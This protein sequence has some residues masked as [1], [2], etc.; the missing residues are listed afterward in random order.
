MFNSLLKAVGSRGDS[1]LVHNFYLAGYFQ[2]L[3]RFF[4]LKVKSCYI[5]LHQKMLVVDIV[6]QTQFLYFL[7]G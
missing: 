3:L 6:T 5:S 4:N 1:N 7:F 2:R